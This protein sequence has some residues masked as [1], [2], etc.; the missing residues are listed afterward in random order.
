LGNFSTKNPLKRL[1]SGDISP[2]KKL[3]PDGVTLH[4]AIVGSRGNNCAL[5]T[6]IPIN[7]KRNETGI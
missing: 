4:L 5:Q 7:S 3:W 2:K 6:A 1:K